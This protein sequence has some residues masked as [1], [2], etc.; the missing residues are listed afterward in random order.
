VVDQEGIMRSSPS[1]LWL[2]WLH[3]AKSRIQSKDGISYTNTLYL[4]VF[5]HK[6]KYTMIYF[7]CLFALPVVVNCSLFVF[8]RVINFVAIWKTCCSLLL[9]QIFTF[10]N[11]QETYLLRA[12][13]IVKIVKIRSLIWPLIC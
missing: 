3:G 11:R 7:S 12:R 9:F 2:S 1:L 4:H 6:F 13:V 8:Y 10:L 5:T